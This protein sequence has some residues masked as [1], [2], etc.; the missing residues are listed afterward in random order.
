MLLQIKYYSHKEDI[1]MKYSFIHALV[2][3]PFESSLTQLDWE[4]IAA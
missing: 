4:T 3:T 2:L 1:G